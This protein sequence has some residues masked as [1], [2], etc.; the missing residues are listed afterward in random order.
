MINRLKY[1]NEILDIGNCLFFLNREVLKT[2]SI[3]YMKSSGEEAILNWRKYY[4]NSYP[5]KL[6]HEPFLILRITFSPARVFHSP[7]FLAGG[8][9]CLF[10]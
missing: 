1:C 2:V 10:A 4:V 7:S 9:G 8:L 6:W 5:L 3:T